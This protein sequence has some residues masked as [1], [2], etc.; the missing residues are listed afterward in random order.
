MVHQWTC[1]F[2]CLLALLPFA[3]AARGPPMQMVIKEDIPEEYV[4][5][6]VIMYK[7]LFAPISQPT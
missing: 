7:P 6:K 2:W 5:A 3:F 4:G 1:T